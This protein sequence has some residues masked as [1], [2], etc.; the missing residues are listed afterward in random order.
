MIKIGIDITFLRDCYDF[1]TGIGIYTKDIIQGICDDD[2]FIVFIFVRKSLAKC[3]SGFFDARVISID[4]NRKINFLN[5]YFIRKIFLK[6]AIK[7]YKIDALLSTRLN[8]YSYRPNNIP[9]FAVLHDMDFLLKNN[10]NNII[11]R[12]LLKRSMRHITYLITIS[13]FVKKQLINWDGYLSN[14]HIKVIYNSIT[15]ENNNSVRIYNKSYILSVNSFKESKNQ[16]TL[17]KAFELIKDRI[18]C[19]LL[20]VGYGNISNIKNYIF[21]NGLSNRIRII[22]NVS[23]SE[24]ANYYVNAKLFVSTSTFEGFGRT[25]VEAGLYGTPV[26]SSMDTSLYEVTCGLVEYYFPSNDFTILADKML[27]ILL[28]DILYGKDRIDKI[29]RVFNDRYNVDKVVKQYVNLI[30][31]EIN[32]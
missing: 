13:E 31:N 25:P 8:G 3:V 5:E 29:Q 21:N 20:L 24:I 6:S 26:I 23:K 32:K 14:K 17:V 7:R 30:S 27:K 12:F 16:I 2:N 15:I 22:Q 4:D 19:D 11:R 18:E 1:N 10:M 9:F 28:G